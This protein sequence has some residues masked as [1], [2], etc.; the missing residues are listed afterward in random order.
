M[1][2]ADTSALFSRTER[3]SPDDRPAAAAERRFGPSAWI[4][5]RLAYGV[6][7]L[8]GVAALTCVAVELLP[9]NAAQLILG[10]QA[11]P[12]QVRLLTEQLGLDR[13]FPLRLLDWL[14]SAIRGDFGTSYLTGEPVWTAIAPRMVNT[15]ILTGL[16]AAVA[17]PASFV[18]GM[19]AARHP[20]GVAD[21]LFNTVTTVLASLPQFVVGIL[22]VMLF[23]TSVFSILPPTA[24]VTSGENP[25]DQPLSLVLPTLAL[26]ASVFPYLANLVRASMLDA[27]NSEYVVMARLKG[28][29]PRVVLWRHALRNAL[30]PAVQGA[31]LSLA[32]MLGGVVV[33]E[34]LFNFPGLGTGLVQSVNERD[35]PTIQAIVVLV[36]TGFVL[37]N[38]VADVLTAYLTPTLRTR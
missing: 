32:F 38:L 4:G 2:S 30:V 24:S 11:T 6:L 22:L 20:R 9:G 35:I 12:E 13:P 28:L 29:R 18:A 1:T 3:Q 34:A 25:L 5:K 16:A 33:I 37:C 8:L 15:L 36:A 17:V 10:A 14:G 31:A 7:T 21:G 23:S 19:W 27:L 26:A